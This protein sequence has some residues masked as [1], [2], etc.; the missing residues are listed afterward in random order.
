MSKIMQIKKKQENNVSQEPWMHKFVIL[1][2]G[3][4]SVAEHGFLFLNKYIYLKSIRR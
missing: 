2:W 4:K 1:R 3:E